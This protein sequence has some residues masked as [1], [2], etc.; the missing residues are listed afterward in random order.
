MTTK[1]DTNTFEPFDKVLIRDK[2]SF[3]WTTGFY[4][5]YEDYGERR[6]YIVNNT[7]WNQCVP[8]NDDTKHLIGTTKMPN[9]KYINW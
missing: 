8:Y 6:F 1:F 7:A 4:S 5:H 9:S 2:D 3:C